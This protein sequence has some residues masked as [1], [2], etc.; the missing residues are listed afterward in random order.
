MR[1]YRSWHIGG[2]LGATEVS[3][4]SYTRAPHTG[5][6]DATRDGR[7]NEDGS[8]TPSEVL[9][10]DSSTYTWST[11]VSDTSMFH[12]EMRCSYCGVKQEMN[13]RFCDCCGAPQ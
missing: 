9:L 8:F 6:W 2:D 11:C 13:A 5:Q 12:R 10:G 1:V 7:L 3:G 4:N